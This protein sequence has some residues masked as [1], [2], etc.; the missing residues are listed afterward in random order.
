MNEA[1]ALAY[2]GYYRDAA[3]LMEPAAERARQSGATGALV[4]FEIVLG[5]I[6]R[7]RGRGL[8]CLRHFS[9]AASLADRAGQG[10][11]LVWAL[12]GLVQGHLLRGEDDAAEDAL[13]R[14][15]AVGYS[16]VGTSMGTRQRALAW[17]A[18]CRGDLPAARRR[19]A[20]V[21]DTAASDGVPVFEIALRHDLVR[22][23]DAAA[24]I[25]CRSWPGSWRVRSSKPWPPTP[26]AR[27]ATTPT[28]CE[29]RS[30]NSRP[31]SRWCWRPETAADLADVLRLEGDAR[32]AAAATQRMARLAERAEEAR[33]PPLR[34]GT[35][36][37]PLTSREREVALLA[38]RGMTTKDIAAHLDLSARTVDT[39]L[40]RIYRKLGVAG[41]ADLADALD[42]SLSAS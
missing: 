7:D 33:T 4:C 34:R 5:E 10:A 3:A 17:L 20:T 37:E 15:D 40:A 28:R 41:R 39:H 36:I 23:G 13:R 29:R 18:A 24:A 21:A 38:A 16:P 6:E 30:T 8:S 1:H 35:G 19:L 26:S 12:I 31:S 22:F 11:T 27:R 25:V 42:D 14:A 32:G 2:V 9:T